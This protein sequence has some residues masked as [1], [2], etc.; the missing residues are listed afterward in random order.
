SIDA[1]QSSLPNSFCPV[2]SISFNI[3][4]RGV[5]VRIGDSAS[6][7]KVFPAITY[8][9]A[10]ALKERYDYNAVVSISVNVTW[11]ATV[12]YSAEKTNPN[13]GVIGVDDNYLQT[14]G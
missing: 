12:R 14:S 1:M 3:R 7:A 6:Q 9:D 5:N 13:I 8:R 11:G 2:R 4:N 10:L